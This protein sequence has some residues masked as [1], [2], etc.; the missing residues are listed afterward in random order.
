MR[1]RMSAKMGNKN[2]NAYKMRKLFKAYDKGDTG[3]VRAARVHCP[4]HAHIACRPWPLWG[5]CAC[6]ALTCARGGACAVGLQVHFEDFRTF[7]ESMGMQ[8]D[9]DSL[10]ALYYVHDPEGR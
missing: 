6:L 3:M 8:L 10:L 2:D 9:D 4:P 7:C 1:E 5:A